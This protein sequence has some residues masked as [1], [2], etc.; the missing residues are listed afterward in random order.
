M[1]NFLN[2]LSILDLHEAKKSLPVALHPADPGKPE[3]KPGEVHPHYSTHRWTPDEVEKIRSHVETHH[4][5]AGENAVDVVT[6][7]AKDVGIERE[8]TSDLIG[9]ASGHEPVEENHPKL[10]RAHRSEDRK[11]FSTPSGERVPVPPS[12]LVDMPAQPTDR[13]TVVMGRQNKH[14]DF[15]DEK[16]EWK[17]KTVMGKDGKPETTDNRIMI[18]A[19]PGVAAPPEPIHDTHEGHRMFSKTPAG[20]ENLKKS[21]EFWSQHALAKPR[22]QT[23]QAKFDFESKF[24]QILSEYIEKRGNSYFV[25]S[26]QGRNLGEFDSRKAAKKRLQQI[27]YFKHAKK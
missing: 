15:Q 18:T 11:H 13:I 14:E 19:Y 3:F 2:F 26:E 23:E 20:E 16:G 27:E 24:S 7:S 9:P 12:R 22:T 17:R 21:R 1:K 6:L 8:L 10:Y 4:P 25:K 5:T